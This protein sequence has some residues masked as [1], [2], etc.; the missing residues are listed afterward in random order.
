ME[1]LLLSALTALFGLLCC[2]NTRAAY[3]NAIY[4]F[5]YFLEEPMHPGCKR[6]RVEFLQ[7][8]TRALDAICKH[9]GYRKNW[10]AGEEVI[11]FEKSNDK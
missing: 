7:L 1:T 8:D 5:C 11:W 9:Y 4:D 10:E 3:R 2:W 6:L